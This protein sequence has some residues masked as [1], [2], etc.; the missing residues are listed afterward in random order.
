MAAWVGQIGGFL[1]IA[2]IVT[3]VFYFLKDLQI[4]KNK[5]ILSKQGKNSIYIAT[6]G[7]LQLMMGALMFN[8]GRGQASA[9]DLKTIWNTEKLSK[10]MAACSDGEDILFSKTGISKLFPALSRFF[11]KRLL[12]QY[13]ASL[14]Y[15]GFFGALLFGLALYLYWGELVKDA[16]VPM[17]SYLCIFLA[18]GAFYLF[19][20]CGISWMLAC[21]TFAL[22]L[23]KKNA[24]LAGILCSCVGI[25]FHVFGS[26]FLIACLIRLLE[27]N[28]SEWIENGIILAGFFICYILNIKFDWLEKWS[29]LCLLYPLAMKLFVTIQ[30]KHRDIIL[31][32]IIPV[33]GFLNGV[34][35]FYVITVDVIM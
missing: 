17:D 9:L 20:P 18:P 14:I 22:Y 29:V 8:Y 19:L 30:L 28:Y 27:S 2:L 15:I 10:M 25:A 16:N 1:M 21:G 11:G 24:K 35:M 6:V 34:L 31:Q 33:L 5:D 13:D 12:E 7:M 3:L 23:M 26:L 4:F 32:S